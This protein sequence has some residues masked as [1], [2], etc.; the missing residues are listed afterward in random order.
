V[1][2]GALWTRYRVRLS[3]TPETGAPRYH[4]PTRRR[5]FLQ[6]KSP[7]YL[8]HAAPQPQGLPWLAPHHLIFR[9]TSTT[10]SFIYMWDLQPGPGHVSG[11]PLT[12]AT[13]NCPLETQL[14]PHAV[15]ESHASEIFVHRRTDH[16]AKV[17]VSEMSDEMHWAECHSRYPRRP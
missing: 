9:A 4:A 8:R 7:P 16:D 6:P 13:R 15:D 10:A 2:R 17:H 11:S 3:R 12:S 14:T 5:P 1:N